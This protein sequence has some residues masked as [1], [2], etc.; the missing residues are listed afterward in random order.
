[1][2]SPFKFL[3]P[4]ELE[5]KNAFFGRDAETKE[6]YNLVTKNRLTFV[7]GPS[8]TGKTS[9]VQCGLSSRFGGVDWLPIFVRRG[10]DINAALRRETGK[11]LGEG[12]ALAGDLPAA[13]AALFSRFLRPV[14]LIFDQF[15]ELFILGNPAEQQAFYDTIA[16]LL[17]AELPC[18]LLF[19]LREDYFG[20]LNQ[21]EKAVP[22]LYHRKLRVEPMSRDNLRAV[23]A[24][25]CHVFNIGFDDARRSPELIMDNITAD[26]SG[27]HMPYVQVYLHML[28]Q[29]A[30]KA[31]QSPMRFS[32]A[33]IGK[34]GPITDV[35]G[36]FLEEQKDFIFKTLQQNPALPS[37]SEDAVPQVLDVFVS[38]EGT[39]VPV[40]YTLTPEGRMSLS[41]KAAHS[42]AVLTPALVSATLLEL[43]K[44]RILRRSD[45]TLELAHDTLAALIDQQRSVELRQLRD[46]RQR[47]ETGWREHTDSGGAYFFDKGQL[48][49]IEPFLTKLALEPEQAGFL[50]K[51]RIEAERL[52][53]AEKERVARELRLAEDKLAAE[54]RARKRQRFFTR[55]VAGVAVVAVSLG[56]FAWYSYRQA[57]EQTK[58]AD[59]AK[60]DAQ[61]SSSLAQKEKEN[62]LHSADTA[63]M[64]TLAAL[65]S[66]SLSKKEKARADQALI[67]AKGNAKI[68]VN[69]LLTVADKA[70]KQLNYTEASEAVNA[71]VRLEAGKPEVA[72]ALL[73]MAF[74]HNHT[75]D[76]K[77]AAKETATAARWLD[78]PDMAAQAE[79]VEAGNALRALRHLQETLSPARLKE[80]NHRYFPEMVPVKGGTFIPGCVKPGD[81]FC[82]KYNKES[83][84]QA[85][86]SDYQ[87]ART[88]TTVW[89]YNLYALA[90]G[91]TINQRLGPD[92]TKAEEDYAPSWGWIGDHPVV[93]VNWYD[94]V[95]YANWASA[96]QGFTP[97]YTILK[98]VRDTNNL[99]DS[100]DFKWTVAINE[101]ANGYRLPTEAE[102]EFAA[103][104]GIRQDPFQYSGS[105]NLD[106]VAWWYSNSGSH[107]HAVRGKQPND[108][109]LYDLTGNVWEWCW[110]WSGDYPQKPETDYRGFPSG[111]SRVLRGGSWSHGG[112][113]SRVA[114]QND[115]NPL[116]R[117]SISGFRVAR[118]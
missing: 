55:L 84:Y 83:L 82:G 9:L 32:D 90:T 21:F 20:H 67:D 43:E 18:R 34:V 24:G 93:Y 71:A 96:Q 40:G 13:V 54:E 65:H 27:I 10:E 42:L 39:K 4:Y 23:I 94:A 16:E 99:S 117:S 100:D 1:M 64:A 11:A 57:K 69:T 85:T 92:S 7:Y 37:V 76:W 66:D 31:G 75:G 79:R 103:R 49:R 60:I 97:V 56:L 89:Q 26:K 109:Q 101:G 86:V 74:F 33:V 95:L 14:Y 2:K 68:A 30:A 91:L 81:D 113:F 111:S 88:E 22:E 87:L 15:E 77:T 59:L 110:D 25:S 28:F 106:E 52:E 72:N 102:W 12:P 38:A 36:R 107:T 35:L 73:E 105:D 108:L 116:N 46:I 61:R 80:L 45:D 3:D 63:R 53:N 78:K 41:G 112:Y 118:H 58:V 8:G 50:E 70:I 51:S 19:I 47:I 114:Y 104:G 17:E 5:D 44:S 48:A 6:L 115:Y 98:S 62:A 29:E